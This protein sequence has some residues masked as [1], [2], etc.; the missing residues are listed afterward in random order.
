MLHDEMQMQRAGQ[1]N[2]LTLFDFQT[3][4]SKK[5]NS[6]KTLSDSNGVCAKQG[7]L[8]LRNRLRR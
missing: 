3:S 7:A 5:N 1:S 2:G 4:L 8:H 6:E